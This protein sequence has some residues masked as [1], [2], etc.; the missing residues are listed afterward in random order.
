MG[1]CRS[2]SNGA[3]SCAAIGPSGRTFCSQHEGG[4][5]GMS[6]YSEAHK[7]P[8]RGGEGWEGGR[9]STC[10]YQT[11]PLALAACTDESE[12]QKREWLPN[13]DLKKGYGSWKKT[14]SVSSLRC[15][16]MWERCGTPRTS[17]RP[18]CGGGKAAAGAASIEAATGR[19][20]PA[21]EPRPWPDG[22]HHVCGAEERRL[23]D[24]SDGGVSRMKTFRPPSTRRRM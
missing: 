9:R 13:S 16:W 2:T 6:T 1:R 18:M 5:G 7:H 24:S 15:G 11:P 19:G 23:D 14:T 12:R 3:R 4:M 20:L 8:G 17:M 21:R 22:E 10:R